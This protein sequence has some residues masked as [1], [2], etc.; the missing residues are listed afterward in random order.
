MRLCALIALYIT[1]VCVCV[2]VFLP[3]LRAVPPDVRVN[4]SCAPPKKSPI[5]PSSFWTS[6]ILGLSSFCVSAK[7]YYF[8]CKL[9]KVYFFYDP[10]YPSVCRSVG[11][12]V[13]WFVGRSVGLSLFP[14]RG[15]KLHLHAAIGALVDIV[16][17]RSSHVVSINISIHIC[18]YIS[19]YLKRFQS[20]N[21][22]H[23]PNNE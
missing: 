19:L 11:L 22:F 13:G 12:S 3:V 6:S 5:I 10:V 16:K 4:L 1:S 21:L 9:L 20:L 2:F 8:I 14:K 7:H 23:N 15:C 17:I 18:T